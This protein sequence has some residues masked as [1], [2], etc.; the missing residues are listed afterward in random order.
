MKDW[1]TLRSKL[2]PDSAGRFAESAFEIFTNLVSGL[3]FCICSSPHPLSHCV[4]L[5]QG[6]VLG[7]E[8]D[9]CSQVW[10]VPRE[11]TG[12]SLS[13]MTFLAG[14]DEVLGPDLVQE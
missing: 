11:D 7:A 1:H 8:E 10:T 4:T 13:A 9:T 5:R 2:R 6:L 14:G 3:S 12:C